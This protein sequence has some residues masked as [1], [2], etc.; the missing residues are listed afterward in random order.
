MAV[1]LMLAVCAQAS[2]FVQNMWAMQQS[3]HENAFR[4]PF[5]GC[6]SDG[7]MGSLKAPHG[8]SKSVV[9]PAD[10]AK[11]LAYYKAEN[12]IGIL[13]PLGWHC[14]GT[15][16][17]DGST[18]YVSPEPINT[19][20]V[21]SSSWK[22]FADE[23][24]QSSISNGD[25]SGRFQVAAVIARIF[26]VHRSFV[27]DVETEGIE[28][29]SSFPSGPYPKDKLTYRSQEVVEF[30]TP[31]NVEGLGTHSRLQKNNNPISGVA[32]LY[33]PELNLLQVSLRLS[34]T[35]NDLSKVIIQQVENDATYIEKSE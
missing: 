7:Q 2:L 9:L 8:Q 34:G 19:V 29:E 25:T 30:E 3:Q 24:I 14:F 17:S 32:I 28:S 6:E 16:G 21:L 31:S 33:G 15:Y 13:A 10:M 35:M 20:D 11:K 4:V 1:T 26:P 12:G 18:L 27:R 23:V 22:G 5:V